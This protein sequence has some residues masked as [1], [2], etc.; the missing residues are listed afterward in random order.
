MAHSKMA[1]LA[2]E[3]IAALRRNSEEYAKF[4]VA[5]DFDAL[6]RLY[7]E[8]AVLL[9][10]RHAAVRGRDAIKRWMAAFPRITL[11]KIDIEEIDT[12]A[13]LAWDFGTCRMTLQPGDPPGPIERVVKYV[14]VHKRQPDG[15]WRIVA[16]IFNADR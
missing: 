10:P 15:S 13:D 8:D 4:L 11:C 1:A 6:A 9:P 12:Q 14:A 5:Q 7:C 3:D 2:A 16:D